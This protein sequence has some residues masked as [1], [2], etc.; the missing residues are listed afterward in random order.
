[1]KST[2]L[3]ELIHL[4]T[5][6]L[7]WANRRKLIVMK[8]SRNR[9]NKQLPVIWIKDEKSNWEDV[10]LQVFALLLGDDPLPPV[11]KPIDRGRNNSHHV[12]N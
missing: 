11:D 6:V 9:K 12:D 2:M 1:M 3:Q 7:C 5:S 10:L 8:K 4:F